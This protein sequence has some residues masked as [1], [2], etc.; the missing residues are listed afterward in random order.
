MVIFATLLPHETTSSEEAELSYRKLMERI[1]RG[2]RVLIDG[3]TGTEVERRGVPQLDNA[4]NGGGTLSHPEIVLDIHEDY[5][6]SGAKIIISNTFATQR[7]TLADAGEEHRFEAFN[8]RAVELALQARERMEADDVVVAGGISYWSFTDRHPPLETLYKN[9][10]EQAAIMADAGAE[11][12]M[13]EMMVNIDRMLVTL[14]AAQTCGLDVWPGLTCAPDQDGKIA[15]LY[16]DSLETAL[17]E[18]SKREVPLISIM[19]TEVEDVNACL[20]VMD[21]HWSGPVGVYAHTGG[22]EDGKWIF[23]NMITPQDYAKA[24][25]G[26]ASRG[27]Q[28]LGG[29][30]GIRSDHIRAVGKAL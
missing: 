4:W 27:V 21:E 13:L 17:Q 19:H 3:A 8:R 29:C 30:C 20:D 22:Y 5:I 28:V 14:E 12:I 1:D 23:E 15:L 25:A 9:T 16:G 11:L 10:V 7:H 26:W 2:E 24:A 6:S 18:L